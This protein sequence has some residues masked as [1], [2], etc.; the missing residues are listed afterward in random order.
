MLLLCGVFITCCN[1]YVEFLIF[2]RHPRYH[3]LNW[4]AAER[5]CSRLLPKMGPTRHSII[6]RSSHILV[7]NAPSFCRFFGRDWRTDFVLHWLFVFMV[8][9]SRHLWHIFW[10]DKGLLTAINF[11]WYVSNQTINRSFYMTIQIKDMIFDGNV[12]P[13]F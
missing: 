7:C 8:S 13:K 10:Y 6:M 4:G 2:K 11:S 1:F 12:T 3:D 5:G 9:S